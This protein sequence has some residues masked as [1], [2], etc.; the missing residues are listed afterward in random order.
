LPDSRDAGWHD[1]LAD[2][3]FAMQGLGM[4]PVTLFGTMPQR[5]W[6]GRTRAGAAIAGFALTEPGSGSDVASST[7]TAE[8]VQGGF[9]LS[10]EK[11][12]NSKA[13][14]RMSTRSSR[15]AARRRGCR[16]SLCPRM[17]AV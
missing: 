13:G 11:T 1:A 10:G 16:A 9:V 3:A 4:G 17:R 8:R 5:E 6:L 12:W 7:M 15:A 14:L 2:F